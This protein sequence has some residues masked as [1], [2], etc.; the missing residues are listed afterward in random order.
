LKK[1]KGAANI[2]LGWLKS[3]E[4]PG[5]RN[6]QQKATDHGQKKAGRDIEKGKPVQDRSLR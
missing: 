6:A 1:D 5:G 4:T 2:N 3:A